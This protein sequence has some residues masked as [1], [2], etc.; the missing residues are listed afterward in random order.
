MQIDTI[1]LI[2]LFSASMTGSPGPANMALMAVG[3]RY[4]YV[5]TLP[6]LLGTNAGFLLTG[7]GVAAG[8]GT[9]FE[10][11]PALKITFLIL[12]AVYILY[13]AYKIAFQDP[14]FSKGQP[15]TGFFAGLFIHPLNP[16]AWAM[17]ITA[18]SQFTGPGWSA[19]EQFLIVQ[20]IFQVIGL[21]LNS[22][23]VYGG[24]LLNQM[25][26]SSNT[27][28]WINRSLASLM[29]IVIGF[30]VWNAGLVT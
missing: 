3:A 6:F 11:F 19:I 5:K 17:L 23:W 2:I 30:S 24:G 25:I 27:M 8:L 22:F 20:S 12:S 15:R 13:L 9:L 26:K 14:N 28:M 21:F 7:I 10:Y 18:Y 1:I 16:K 4:G 29:L